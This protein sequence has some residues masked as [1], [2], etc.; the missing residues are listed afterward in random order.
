M[1]HFRFSLLLSSRLFFSVG[2]HRDGSATS[3]A[4]TPAKSQKCEKV[5]FPQRTAAKKGAEESFG[6]FR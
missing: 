6:L 4:A 1:K 2:D 3:A 5:G